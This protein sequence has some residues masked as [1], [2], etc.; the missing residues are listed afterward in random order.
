MIGL[1]TVIDQLAASD[2]KTFTQEYVVTAEN[3]GEM[4]NIATAS[5]EIDGNQVIQESSVVVKVTEDKGLVGGVS[6]TIDKI[7]DWG[8]NPQTGDATTNTFIILI[9]FALAGVGLY[10]YKR[11]QRG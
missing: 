6:T 3:V 9:V 10:V 1:V 4:K 2:S 8:K 11:K 7:I 5:I